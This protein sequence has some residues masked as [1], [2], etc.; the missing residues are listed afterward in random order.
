LPGKRSTFVLL[1]LMFTLSFFSVASASFS[2]GDNG[3]EVLDIQKQLA[4]LN[5]HVGVLDGDFGSGT[6]NA[7]MSYQ[8]DH[9]LEADGVVGE[10]TYRSL[11]NRPMPVNRSGGHSGRIGRVLR[12]AYSMSGVPYVFGG[13][14]PYG[15]DCSGFTQYAF[16]SAGIYLPRTADDQYYSYRKVSSDALRPGDLV[17]FETYCDG[18]S[19]VGIYVGD[20][21]MIHAGSSTGVAVASIFSGYWGARYYGAARVR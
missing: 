15:F 8:K 6:E 20:G 16:A 17:F 19:H 14:S 4:S 1:V 18:P 7:V 10:E 2:Y 21:Q 5:Y 9:G 13:T 3:Q 12:T 11:M